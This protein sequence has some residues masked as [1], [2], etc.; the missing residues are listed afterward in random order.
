MR[1]KT[2]LVCFVGLSAAVEAAQASFLSPIAR[3]LE[4]RQQQGGQLGK[5][6]GGRGDGSSGD[7]QGGNQGNN[8]GSKNGGDDGLT[9]RA[10]LVQTASQDDGNNPGED[11]QAAS[12]TVFVNPQNGAN[13]AANQDFTI[14]VQMINFKAGAFTNASSNYYSAPQDLDDSG[15]IIGHTHVVIQDTGRG[16]N[17]K[18]PLD[19]TRFAFFKGINDAGN[20][21]GLLAAEVTGGLPAGNYR[22]CSMSAAAN[23]QPVLMPVAQRGAQDDCVR[24]TVGGSGGDGKAKGSGKGGGNANGGRQG[25]QQG[26][27]QGQQGQQEQQEQ[28]GQQGQQ[29][30]QEQQKQQEQQEGQPG[31]DNEN[32]GT[33]NAQLPGTQGVKQGQAQN[34]NQ[35]TGQ[36]EAQDDIQIQEGQERSQTQNQAAGRQGGKQTAEQSGLAGAGD[37]NNA[38]AAAAAAAGNSEFIVHNP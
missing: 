2:L 18:R 38:A 23:H 22:L 16:L 24:F 1:L 5:N 19:P 20:N 9:L 34:D 26:G 28:Q 25:E 37:I 36:A 27:Q 4:L 13:L 32:G 7:N 21:R 33:N 11:G 30:Q 31:V 14:K 12:A 3:I 29:E 35:S 17:P 8:R 6:A 15:N 10:D